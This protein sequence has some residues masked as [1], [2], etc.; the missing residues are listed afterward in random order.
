MNLDEL[1]DD[2]RRNAHVAKVAQKR[3]APPEK[4]DA[5]RLFLD[6]ENWTRTKGIALVHKE[7][8]SI[9]GNFSEYTH[10]KL[11]GVRKLLREEAPIAVSATE[12]VEGSWW[13]G[14]GRKPEPK[15]V[16][17]EQRHCI[18]HLYLEELRVHSPVCEVTAHL[19]YGAIAR[20]ELSLDTQFAQ[21]EGK[22]QML[23]LPAG[24]NISEVM[25]LEMKMIL[26]KELGL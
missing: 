22:E 26:R 15:Q 9:I 24:T 25:H 3:D 7:T 13:L 11:P 4:P 1:W 14:E 6:S 12:I 2:T 10:N 23:F 18:I 17:H 16:W 19:S 20:V 21:T 8:Q 5:K